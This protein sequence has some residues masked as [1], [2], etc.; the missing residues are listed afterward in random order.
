MAIPAYERGK[1]QICWTDPFELDETLQVHSWNGHYIT[2]DK[3][4]LSETKKIHG[5]C[6]EC[7]QAVHISENL[8]KCY[9]CKYSFPNGK[10]SVFAITRD[11]QLVNEILAPS[12]ND[13]LNNP[14]LAFRIEQ[15]SVNVFKGLCGLEGLLCLAICVSLVTQVVVVATRGSMSPDFESSVISIAR[16]VDEKSKL[17]ILP[18][19]VLMLPIFMISMIAG[20]TKE[21]T[22]PHLAHI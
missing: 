22:R 2:S 9:T 7:L 3:G 18:L 10:R 11:G 12:V 8:L 4:Q 15:V 20:V 5:I 17:A 16:I 1:C 19:F 6:Q 21:L 13:I 14:F